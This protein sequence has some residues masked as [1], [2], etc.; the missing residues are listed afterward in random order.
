MTD[1]LLPIYPKKRRGRWI[2]RN[3]KGLRRARR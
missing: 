3:P 1:D 2:T